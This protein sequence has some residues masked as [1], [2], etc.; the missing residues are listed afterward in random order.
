MYFLCYITSSTWREGQDE[1]KAFAENN[2]SHCDAGEGRD[3][4]FDGLPLRVFVCVVRACKHGI[5]LQ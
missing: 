2:T 5:Y 1:G 4:S 3:E